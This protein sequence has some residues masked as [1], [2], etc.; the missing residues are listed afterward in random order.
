MHP[1][2]LGGAGRT[3]DIHQQ[4]VY[5]QPPQQYK[6]LRPRDV[7]LYGTWIAVVVGFFVGALWGVS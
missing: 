4:P 6:P 2:G 7:L 5:I 1:S 3:G